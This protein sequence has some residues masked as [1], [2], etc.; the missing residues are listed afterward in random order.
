MASLEWEKTQPL[1]WDFPEVAFRSSL[2]VHREESEYLHSIN[3]AEQILEEISAS[4]ERE[5]KNFLKL[6]NRGEFDTEEGVKCLIGDWTKFRRPLCFIRIL[7]E[8]DARN[9]LYL[10]NATG[11]KQPRERVHRLIGDY[12]MKVGLRIAHTDESRKHNEDVPEDVYVEAFVLENPNGAGNPHAR[13]GL[14]CGDILKIV[15]PHDDKRFRVHLF[16][17]EWM[18]GPRRGIENLFKVDDDDNEAVK[19]SNS[20]NTEEGE[21][22][23][24]WNETDG[25][26]L[27][28]MDSKLAE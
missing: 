5:N 23:G 19:D 11:Y 18:S 7:G 2:Y 13:R 27:N 21:D 26:D 12:T 8:K 1:M 6:W 14:D 15:Y 20:E 22:E 4:F 25:F 10:Q 24:D 16:E 28:D 3:K 9:P 17:E